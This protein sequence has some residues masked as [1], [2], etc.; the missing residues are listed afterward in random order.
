[1][2]DYATGPCES[3]YIHYRRVIKLNNNFCCLTVQFL[4]L[5]CFSFQMVIREIWHKSRQY[6]SMNP[7]LCGIVKLNF[8]QWFSYSLIQ[9]WIQEEWKLRTSR[10]FWFCFPDGRTETMCEFNDHLS[11]GAWW[12]KK[13]FFFY[14][15]S[16]DFFFGWLWEME[17]IRI[18]AF[19]DISFLAFLRNKK[20]N[21]GRQWSTQPFQKILS[22]V[23][24]IIWRLCSFD[25]KV[26]ELDFKIC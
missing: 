4:S 13:S 9:A 6:P 14:H 21:R 5:L 16:K 24:I 17:T 18:N 3:L 20:K 8:H 7:G 22:I 15:Y 10:M 2:T 11:A 19:V 23:N 26:E 25:L 1:M 12:V